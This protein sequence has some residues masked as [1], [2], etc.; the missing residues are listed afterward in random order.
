MNASN[1]RGLILTKNKEMEQVLDPR[2]DEFVKQFKTAIETAYDE[3]KAYKFAG[4]KLVGIAIED[5]DME[6]LESIEFDASSWVLGGSETFEKGYGFPTFWEFIDQPY[7]E[8]ETHELAGQIN[9]EIYD[10]RYLVTE[11]EKR[12]FKC[13]ADIGNFKLIVAFEI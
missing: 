11:F 10:L 6:N 1:L 2:V 7:K 9:F 8:W 4:C 5:V 13:Y 3:G 12:G